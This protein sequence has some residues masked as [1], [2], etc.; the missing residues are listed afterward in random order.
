MERNIIKHCQE[1]DNNRLR[2]DTDTQSTSS[3]AMTT[4]H[5]MPKR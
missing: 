3:S 5:Q 4:G 2:V 1:R